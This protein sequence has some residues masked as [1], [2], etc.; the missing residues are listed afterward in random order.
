ME[1]LLKPIEYIPKYF[2]VLTK[3]DEFGMSELSPMIL[4]PA[5]AHYIENRT[6]RNIVLKGR[7]MGISTA[8]M[9]ANSYDVFN[10]PNQRMTIITHDD[11]TS[12]F[13][14][15]TVKR[16]YKYLPKEMKPKPGWDSGRHLTY[17]TIEAYIYIDSAKSDSIGIGHGL[18]IA[19]LSEIAKW[20]SRKEHQLFTDISQT[21]P[22]GGFI[23][24]ESTPKG[25]GGLFYDLWTAAKKGSVEYKWFFYPWWWD[26]NYIEDPQVWMTSEKLSLAA[27][28]INESPES[29]HK[30]EQ[31]L[32]EKEGLSP[33]QLAW[34]R[35]KLC[36]IK[37]GF[38]QEYPENDVD[39]W[40]SSEVSVFDGVAIRRYLQQIKEGRQ[41]GN[42]TV[43]KDVIGGEKYVMG[44]DP[45]G[46]LPKGDYSVASVLRVKTNEYV[47][48]IRGRLPPDL[49]AQ[50][51]LR[52]GQRYNWA[53]I[54][55]ERIGHG[56]T[57]L[58]ILMEQNYPEIYHHQDYD[59]II[60]NTLSQ[61]GWKTSG[62]TKP[63]MV[64]SMKAALRADDITLWSENFLMEASGYIVEGNTYTKPPGGNDDELDALMIALQLR[65]NMPLI[66]PARSGVISY[67][68]L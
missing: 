58:R 39:C 19:H 38:Y 28:R 60:G 25:R 68:R 16:F 18:T 17:P 23:T 45:A 13:L 27:E 53:E 31:L 67:A 15:M 29:L 48:R 65:E 33:A 41:E 59:T 49:F 55:V 21:V 43:W 66:E 52:L 32:V 56:G 62:K 44:V 14:L 3:A 51:I 63:I 64:D 5:Q 26:G 2:K 47:A 1:E 6:H 24:V 35:S 30:F 9:A 46:G 36:E 8:V 54:G 22:A 12:Q 50:E 40:F 11:E 37:E 57:V 20:P 34:R 7:Q 4:W 10:Y 61:P 42:L